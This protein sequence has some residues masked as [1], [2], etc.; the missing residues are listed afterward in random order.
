MCT[1]VGLVKGCVVPK[2]HLGY[3]NTCAH[4]TEGIR[5]WALATSGH[6]ALIISSWCRNGIEEALEY[7]SKIYVDIAVDI[8]HLRL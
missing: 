3:A 5:A 1:A 6:D 7:V 4:W 2:A 8:N